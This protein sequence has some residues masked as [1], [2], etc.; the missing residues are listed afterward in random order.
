MTAGLL[1]QQQPASARG[2]ATLELSYERYYPRIK[3]GGEFYGKELRSLV[4][5]NDWTGIK[6]AL[7]EVPDRTKA[8]LNKPDAGVAARARQAGGF[9]DARV[10]TAADLYA[11]AFSDNS[12]SPKTKKMKASIE[13]VRAAVQGMNSVAKQALGEEG[14]GGFFG[15]GQ[16]KPNETELKKNL[17]DYYVMGGNAWNEYIVAANDDLALKFDRFPILK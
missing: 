13:K 8:D 14:G 9:S 2:R 15:L 6:N 16:K 3:A 17:R 12:I 4:A 11:G 10:L 5:T 7:A 1:A